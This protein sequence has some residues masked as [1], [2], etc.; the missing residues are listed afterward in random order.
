VDVE[1]E[2]VVVRVEEEMLAAPAGAVE[3]PTFERR[4][5]RVVRLQRG[6][7]RRAGSLDRERGDRVV[8]DP[9]V[10]L[11]LGKLGNSSSSWT[12]SA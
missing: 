10:R 12:R 11:D 8:E 3:P 7:V 4:E 2:L 1:D 5:R 9:P 6:D